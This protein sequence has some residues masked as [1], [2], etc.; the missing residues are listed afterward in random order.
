M[1]IGRSIVFLIIFSLAAMPPLFAK[2]WFVC[3]GSFR[4]RANAEQFKES[5][6]AQSVPTFVSKAENAG[7]TLY[8]VLLSEPFSNAKDALKLRDGIEQ[9]LKKHIEINSRLWVCLA[10]P[11]NHAEPEKR[12]IHVTDSDTGNPIALARLTVDE[13]M[14][15]TT[16]E[17]GDAELPDGLSDGQHSLLIESDG[18]IATKTNFST[19]GGAVQTPPSYSVARVV[20]G[21]GGSI[22]VVLNWG[23]LPANL[24]LH[25][26]SGARHVYFDNMHSSGS[27]VIDLDRDDIDYEGPETITVHNRSEEA[28]YQFYIHDYTNKSSPSSSDLSQSGARVQLAIDNADIGTYSVPIRKTGIW[29][30][31]FDI[32]N[33]NVVVHNTVSAT[34]E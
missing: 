21:E 16:D 4:E 20:E 10:D 23:L 3:L 8:R 24:D 26:F 19:E 15:T 11:P 13:T 33:G 25:V 12:M 27:D 34:R 6:A 22:K 1:K 9:P 32:E 31:I 7:Q 14:R 2:D 29:W 5:L 28:L 18:H 30:H 17:A